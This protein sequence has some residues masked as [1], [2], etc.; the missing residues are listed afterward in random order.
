MVLSFLLDQLGGLGYAPLVGASVTA[1]VDAAAGSIVS[2]GLG[3]TDIVGSG[4]NGIV[5]IGISVFEEGHDGDVASITA[6][7]GAG[8]TLSFSVGAG[9]T[10]YSDPQ[11]FVSEPT[12][13]NLE[14]VGVSRIGEGATTNTGTGLLLNVNV[15]A[16]STVGVGSTYHSVNS[17]SIAR[18]GYAFRK[19]DVFKPVGLVTA[20]GLASPLSEFELTV[21]ETYSDNFGAWQFGELDF[22]DSVANYPRWIKN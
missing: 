1:V 8:G 16:S 5:A 20:A 7:V 14:V 15:G 2:V 10:G 11:I 17:F 13:E 4:Y 12:Y 9:G 21:L 18:S 22:I 6:T 19:G 3:S